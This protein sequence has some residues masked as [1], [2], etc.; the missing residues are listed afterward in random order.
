MSRER[1]ELALEKLTPGQ[2]E[3][4]ERFASEFLSAEIPDLRT[5][6]L[7]SGDS[8]RDAEIFSPKGDAS[9]VLQYSVAQDW[10]SKIRA[11]A[12][13]VSSTLQSA[14]MLIYVTNQKIGADVDDLR[15]EIRTTYSLH[16]DVRDRAYFLDRLRKSSQTE[17]A[18]EELAR[19]IV[20]PYLSSRRIGPTQASALD[21]DEL[22][23]ALL[24]LTLQLR[25]E[26]QEKGLTKLSFEALI[27][28]VLID[29][30][31]EH[32]MTRDEIKHRVRQ[33]LPADDPNRVDQLTESGLA[34]LTKRSIRHWTKSDEFCLTFEETERLS[35]FATKRELA[36]VEILDELRDAIEKRRP[37]AASLPEDTTYIATRIRRLLDRCLYQRAELFAT[38]ILAGSIST[39]PTDHLPEI[40]NDDLRVNIPRKGDL[41]GDQQWLLALVREILGDP[42]DATQLYISDLAD[43]YTLL[44]FL[45]QTPDVQSA[46]QKIFSHGEIWL[47]TSAILPLLAEEVL[48]DKRRRFQQMYQIA[49]QAGIK[50][51][52][53]SGVIEELERHINRAVHCSHIA[54]Q[55]EG[56]IP[57]LLEIFLQSGRA[58]SEFQSWTE[59]FRGS[60]RPLEDIFEY[61]DTRFGI[62]RHD[63]EARAN[64]A[65]E[66]LRQTIQ[67]I[68]YEIHSRRREKSGV[69]ADPI[70]LSRLSRHDAENYVGVIQQR[71]Q[72]KPSA[73]GYSAWWLTLDRKAF[74]IGD[75]AKQQYGIQVPD[76]PVL[77]LDFLAQYL[78]IGPARSR[79]PKDSIR[80]LHVFLEPRLVSFLT[81]DLIGEATSIRTEMQDKPEWVIRR[82][83]RD[84]LDGARRRMGPL[85]AQ[86]LDA[87]FEI[88]RVTL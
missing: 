43:S 30:D 48:E 14:Q 53:T 80:G 44:A 32:R 20:D 64:E 46:V 41:D 75:V 25:D 2:W 47:D 61:L 45:R 16:L 60:L 29:S 33:L 51:F 57:F 37:S 72:E 1:L 84:H 24:Y 27:R 31:S 3:R 5:V 6:A 36:E 40:I 7:P 59:T 21:K 62:Q 87:F 17:A 70:M 49:S 11:T 26:V 88:D 18:S 77:S 63:L 71:H 54:N 83:I 86:S 10:R 66:R 65:P 28:S 22:R 81:R 73:F 55:W 78:T 8:G 50:F 39:F 15:S 12:K 56:R 76:S 4:F 52:A 79:L 19:D 85:A 9:Q 13:R 42:G 23:A 34:R 67:E 58:I 35:N 82:R 38:A 68:W 69:A 74:A